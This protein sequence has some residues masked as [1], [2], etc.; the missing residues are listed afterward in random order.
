LYLEDV[1]CYVSDTDKYFHAL[2]YVYDNVNTAAII[3][4]GL[5][6]VHFCRADEESSEVA[7]NG[8]QQGRI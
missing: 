4:I 2:G 7:A 6:A 1:T 3:A 5:F 8:L